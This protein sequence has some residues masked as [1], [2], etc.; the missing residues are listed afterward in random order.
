MFQKDNGA[1]DMNEQIARQEPQCVWK[2]FAALCDIPHSSGNEAGVR[3]YLRHIAERAGL[4]CKVDK[5]GNLMISKPASLGW[6]GCRTVILQ[7]H[8]DMV[9]QVKAGTEFNFDTDRIPAVIK[10]GWVISECA[11]L[12]ADNGIGI[13]LAM[14]ALLDDSY[15]HIP[16]RV[17]FTVQ[18]ETGLNG[19]F[20]LSPE[21]VEYPHMMI[22]LDSEELRKIYIG[23]AGGARVG[24]TFVP[25]WEFPPPDQFTLKA[26][27]GGLIGGHSGADIHLDR[28][29]AIKLLNRFLQDAAK[30]HI[31][32]STIQGGNR[33]NVIPRDASAVI[34]V[35]GNDKD[36]LLALAE[37]YHQELRE[38]Y[39]TNEPEIFFQLENHPCAKKVFAGEFQTRL[40][41]AIEACPHGVLE[42]SDC[43]PGLVG[44]SNNLAGISTAPDI[45]RITTSQRSNNDSKRSQITSGI[46]A[47]FEKFGA[48]PHISNTYPGWEPRPESRLVLAFQEAAQEILGQE[49]EVT[50]LHAGLECG[51][52]GA[53]NRNLDIVSFGPDIEGVHAPGE[54][55]NIESVRKC[56]EILKLVLA[57]SG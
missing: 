21:W 26:T 43:I 35:S 17:I 11:T 39:A 56:W 50:A 10:D 14:A 55:V 40:L 18:E 3:E 20:A 12:G 23:C 5:C 7:A 28:G 49:L 46:A 36:A 37:A 4:H 31:R 9:P 22:N 54:R 45:V 13:A 1:I 44:S 51:I 30:F 8:M 42:M 24:F 57:R 47:L 52:I 27:I 6:T 15:N 32:I 29:N 2:I 16:L 33:D 38:Q 25:S 34:T 19:A 41:A 48:V 53:L